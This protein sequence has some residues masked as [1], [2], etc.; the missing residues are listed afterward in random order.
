MTGAMRTWSLFNAWGLAVVVWL[1]WA[2][3]IYQFLR[4][5]VTGQDIMLVA[6]LGLACVVIDRVRR[7]VTVEL[8]RAR[9]G[10]D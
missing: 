2:D 5:I 6:G 8:K 7:L 1:L 4:A 9:R 10:D 3:F